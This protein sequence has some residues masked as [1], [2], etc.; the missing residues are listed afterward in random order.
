MVTIN[1]QPQ[2]RRKEPRIPRKPQQERDHAEQ[3]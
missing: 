2:H 3:L 1:K